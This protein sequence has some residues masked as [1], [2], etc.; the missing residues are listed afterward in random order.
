MLLFVGV[1]AAGAPQG[2]RATHAVCCRSALFTLG[3]GRLGTKRVEDRP[4]SSRSDDDT[5]FFTA[6]IFD[7]EIRETA[8]GTKP[9]KLD[10]RDGVIMQ[11]AARISCPAA[12][13]ASVSSRMAGTRIARP[14]PIAQFQSGINHR[15]AG[16]PD[17]SAIANH[18]ID[19]YQD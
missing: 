17:S 3:R 13:M 7:D 4:S 11:R 14:L 5:R 16:S 19:S 8:A 10:D 9:T 12:A 6:S 2:R 18:L 15:I 1:R